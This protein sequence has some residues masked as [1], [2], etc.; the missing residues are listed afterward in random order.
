MEIKK[1]INYRGRVLEEFLKNQGKKNEIDKNNERNP[2]ASELIYLSQILKTHRGLVYIAWRLANFHEIQTGK[3]NKTENQS[4]LSGLILCL[5]WA[6]QNGH[7]GVVFSQLKKE[8]LENVTHLNDHLDYSLKN[9]KNYVHQ[10]LNLDLVKNSFGIFSFI[11]ENENKYPES[12][13]YYLKKSNISEDDFFIISHKDYFQQQFLLKQLLARVHQSSFYFNSKKEVVKAIQ[14]TFITK[15]AVKYKLDKKQLE[16]IEFVLHSNFIILTGGPGTGKTTTAL[17]IIRAYLISRSSSK[18]EMELK[19][20]LAAPTGRAAQKLLES[21]KSQ[22]TE[23]FWDAYLSQLESMT[24]HRLLGLGGRINRPKYNE[25]EKLPYDF[26]LIDESS[27][28]SLE[29]MYFLFKALSEKTTLVLMGDRD[30]LPAVGSGSLFADIV[31]PESVKNSLTKNIKRLDK[32]FRSESQ[33][34]LEQAK[35]VIKGKMDD[36][37]SSFPKSKKENNSSPLWIENL[38]QNLLS[39]TN[40]SL[41]APHCDFTTEYFID[42]PNKLIELQKEKLKGLLETSNQKII[43]S[44]SKTGENGTDMINQKILKQSGSR[45]F[46]AGMPILILENNSHLGLYN[47]D[48]GLLLKLKI[49]KKILDFALF[50]HSEE[51]V[52]LYPVYHLPQWE[53]AYAMTVHKSQGSEYEIVYLVVGRTNSRLLNREII[54]TGITRAKK[55]YILFG[56][57]EDIQIAIKNATSRM[58]LI[59]MS[60]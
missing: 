29:M 39:L 6:Q 10:C 45:K 32:N 46:P 34:I 24:I 37:L 36:F 58:S 43:L 49:N 52:V 19:I 57:K 38:P 11:D 48:R 60:L 1:N 47:G 13:F 40:F 42:H 9:L 2:I 22:L 56:R 7:I 27:M 55:K 59:K 17:N 21:I 53:P 20:A 41:L 15:E 16:V 50:K 44:I 33:L 14:E 30:Q 4:F 28:M 3:L 31:P 23:N 35:M 51:T 5:L 25:K 8:I 18:N 12:F 54:Y 26:L